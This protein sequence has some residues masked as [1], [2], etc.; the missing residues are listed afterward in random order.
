MPK[1]PDIKKVLVIGSG[2]I[3]IGQAAEFDYSGSQACKALRE[4]GV[5]TVLVNSNPATIQ[6]DTDIADT[7]YIEPLVPEIVAEIIRRERPDALLPS[8]GGQTGLNLSVQLKEMGVL[9][10]MGVEVIGTPVESI[11]AAEDRRLFYEL[12]RGIGERMP[13]SVEVRS[14]EDALGVAEELGYPILSRPSYCLGGTGSGVAFNQEEL[15]QIVRRGLAL[16]LN[17]TVA[18]DQCVLGWKEIE[19]EVMR[20]CADN[21]I[22]ICCME[23][24]DPMGI[25]TGDSIVVAPSQTLSDHEYQTLRSASLKVIRALKLNGGCNIQFAVNP[26]NFEYYVIEVNPRVSRS[27]A[28]ASKATGY[29]IARIA[30]KLALEMML[31]EIPNPVTR[32][33]PAS[34][35]PA[36]DYVV[37]KIPRWPFDKFPEADQVIGTQMKGTG[38]V[39]AIGRTFEEALQKAVRSLEIGRYGLDGGGEGITDREQLVHLL[40]HPTDKRIFHL[41]DALRLGMSVEEIYRLTWIDPWFLWKLKKILV[42]EERLREA[43]SNGIGPELLKEAKRMG[44]SDRQL[45]SLLGKRED[46]IRSLRKG[47][48]M[49]PAFKTVDTCAAEFA[50]RTPYYYSSYEDVDEVPV[51]DRKKVIIIG[52]GPIRIGQGIEFDYCCVHAAFALR[53]EGIEAI[54]INNNPETVS[55]DSDTSDK[56]YFEPLTFEDVMNV[57]E[58]EKPYGVIVQLGGQT[59]LNLAVRLAKAG[60]NILGTSADNIDIAEDRER[61]NQLLRKL[62]ISQPPGG[63]SFSLEGAKEIARRI[64]FPVLVRPSYVLGGRAMVKVHDEA[65]LE[66]Y[67]VE[68]TRVS[69]DHPVLVDKFI[70]NAIEVDVDVVSDG[71]RTFIGGILEHIEE[72]GVHSGDASMVMPPQTLSKRA[73]ETIKDY[74]LRLSKELNVVGLMNVQYAVK[75]DTV[76]VLEVNPRASR[77]VPFISK[78]IGI[79]LAKV[80][81]KVMLGH[82]LDELGIPDEVQ[83][84]YVCVKESVFPFIK[85]PG[86]DPVLGP[87]MKSTGEVMGIDADFGRAYFKSQLAAGN[88]LPTKGRIFISVCKE[89][90]PKVVPIARRLQELGFGILATEGTKAVLEEAGVGCELVRKVSQGSPNVLDKIRKGDVDLIINTPTVGRNQARD[91][92]MIRRAAIDLRI[93][94]VTTIAGAQAAVQAIESLVK[95]RMS[96]GSLNEYHPKVERR[97]RPREAI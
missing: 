57:I 5:K 77:T 55:T 25:H 80:A 52:G 71:R 31:D 58:K 43:R 91:G 38:E 97:F 56:L 11:M 22:T 83:L 21:C 87:E 62:N 72:A 63:T 73:I 28:L 89:D 78:A 45:A 6:T 35:E 10:E 74:T 48:K 46:E 37:V 75:G 3:V 66:R 53:E 9:D 64:G 29:P 82:T 94:Y 23:N 4:E 41:M 33:T 17:R 26:S 47:M 36:V 51:S 61:F 76:Y 68:A 32:D 70:P 79:P 27:S 15:V 44:F 1:R 42:V 18:L 92:Y 59:P 16:S 20:D 81:V 34:F 49:V 40:R 7:V 8:M 96:I 60:V 67:M 13:M 93:P 95:G 90:K 86:V 14:V 2:P 88:T 84:P 19:F 24:F 65:E 54:I 50:A 69:E 85:L 12:V 30:S 39:M